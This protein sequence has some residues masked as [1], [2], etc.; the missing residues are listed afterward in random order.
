MGVVVHRPPSASLGQ[1]VLR[2]GMQ[3]PLLL[4]C[5]PKPPRLAAAVFRRTSR[6]AIK[7]CCQAVA[8]AS[9]SSSSSG[10]VEL[11]RDAE[12][13]YRK[14]RDLLPLLETAR[15]T[16][17]H[18]RGPARDSESI[19]QES[20]RRL[21]TLHDEI[22]NSTARLRSSLVEAAGGDAAATAHLVQHHV[23]FRMQRVKAQLEP[24]DWQVRAAEVGWWTTV[25]CCNVTA[26]WQLGAGRLSWAL[27]TCWSASFERPVAG[28]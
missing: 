27:C 8:N 5:G 13:D 23:H 14:A 10:F 15:Q 17:S 18:A 1:G 28:L 24:K 3:R 6:A 2:A 26:L 21:S 22:S 25:H 19:W 20:H 11:K 7:R 12:S 4:R 9:S 16:A